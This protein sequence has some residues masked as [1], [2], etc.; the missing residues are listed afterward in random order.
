MVYAY[1]FHSN[2]PFEFECGTTKKPLT[3]AGLKTF[4][5]KGFSLPYHVTGS[6]ETQGYDKRIWGNGVV[7]SGLDIYQK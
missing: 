3:M 2:S 5:A 4:E 1:L 7:A 6:C